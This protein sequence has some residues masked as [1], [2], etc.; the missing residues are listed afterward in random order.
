M[1]PRGVVAA[2]L[3]QRADRT[4]VE[5]ELLGGSQ[6]EVAAV[7]VLRRGARRQGGGV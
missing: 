4:L 7:D 1:E 3:E 5:G 2:G 6:E